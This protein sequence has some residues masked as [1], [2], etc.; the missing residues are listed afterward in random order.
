MGIY[1]GGL[2]YQPYRVKGIRVKVSAATLPSTIGF[3]DSSPPLGLTDL[4]TGDHSHSMVPGGLLVIS[5]T[6]RLT[7]RTSLV[8]RV[9]MVASTS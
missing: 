8:M 7:S 1:Q 9:E 5:S 2:I 4:P 6:T 3:A